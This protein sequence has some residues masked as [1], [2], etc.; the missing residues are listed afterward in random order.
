MS[1]FKLGYTSHSDIDNEEEKQMKGRVETNKN[2][3]K[4]SENTIFF[5]N[6]KTILNGLS[7]ISSLTKCTVTLVGNTKKRGA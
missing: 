1:L 5:P 2:M 4:K 6:E 7:I 3:K